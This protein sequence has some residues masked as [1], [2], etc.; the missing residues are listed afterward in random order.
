[1]GDTTQAAL[2]FDIAPD[3]QPGAQILLDDGLIEMVV[4]QAVKDGVLCRVV[5]GGELKDHKSVNVPGVDLKMPYVSDKDRDDILFGIKND[6]DYIAASFCRSAEDVL[7]IRRILE[8]NGGKN[9]QIIAKIENQSGVD[10]IDA[11]L[12]VC[13]GIMVARGDM[14]VEMDIVDLPR[15][16][17]MLIKKGY[18]TGK[19]GDY[20]DADAGFDDPQRAA[21]AR[22][23]DGCG[24]RSV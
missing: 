19:K 18:S 24:Q 22:G 5:S 8:K 10:H 17:K 16:Q 20:R 15:I 2:T 6:V 12:D 21:D 7:D 13:D 14:G 1:M 4:E 23:G 3:V 11:I 9:I